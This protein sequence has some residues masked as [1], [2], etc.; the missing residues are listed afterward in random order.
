MK[1]AYTNGIDS[2]EAVS[3]LL[4]YLI[5]S[6]V[7][8]LL[9]IIMTLSIVPVFIAGPMNQLNYYAYNDI[10]NGVSTRIVDLYTIIPEQN[11]GSYNS[12]FYYINVNISS[13]F[14][15]PDEI[16]GRGYFVEVTKGATRNGS[17]IVSGDGPETQISLSGIGETIGVI[18]RTSSGGLNEI[19]YHI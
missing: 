4:E 3:H 9:M 19:T 10:G 2:E 12:R 18:G 6:G 1:Y 11:T 15:I 17:L 8:I 16:A 13:K 7:L 5:I 14:D